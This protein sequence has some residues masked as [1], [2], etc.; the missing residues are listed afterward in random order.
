MVLCPPSRPESPGSGGGDPWGGAGICRGPRGCPPYPPAAEHCTQSQS[1]RAPGRL[2]PTDHGT[3]GIL[4]RTGGEETGHT[5]RTVQHSL[6]A[7]FPVGRRDWGPGSSPLREGDSSEASAPTSPS[8]G[9]SLAFPAPPVAPA[10]RRTSLGLSGPTRGLRPTLSP[11]SDMADSSAPFRPPVPGTAAFGKCVVRMVRGKGH[12][13]AECWLGVEGLPMT[14]WP[15][16]PLYAQ[17]REVPDSKKSTWGGDRG[18][19]G[20]TSDS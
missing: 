3:H 14:G 1:Q 11:L 16:I 17:Q 6:Q 4:Q 9:T 10:E 12:P 2:C 19:V 20:Y 7:V 5:T 18:S 8:S 15:Q 13:G